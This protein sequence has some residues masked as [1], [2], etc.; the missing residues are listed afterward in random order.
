MHRGL[1]SWVGLGS[2]MS[3]TSELLF[4]ASVKSSATFTWSS[5]KPCSGSGTSV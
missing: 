5:D 3:I 2:G 1:P 4:G